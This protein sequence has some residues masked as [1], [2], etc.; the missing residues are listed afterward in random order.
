MT[1]AMV[2]DQKR[3]FLNMQTN[4]LRHF[5]K[6]YSLLNV[7]GLGKKKGTNSDPLEIP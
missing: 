3:E 4:L 5:D 1:Q 7:L 6:Q 2:T